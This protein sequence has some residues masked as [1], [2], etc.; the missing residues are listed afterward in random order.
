MDDKTRDI[1]ARISAAAPNGTI[2]CAEAL[3]LAEELSLTPAEIG[4]AADEL[5]V[6]IVRCQLGCF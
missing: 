4:Q 5:K 2:S 3:R 1:H 6:R